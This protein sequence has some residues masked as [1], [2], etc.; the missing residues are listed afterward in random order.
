MKREGWFIVD[1]DLILGRRNMQ[2]K[3]LKRTKK[4][5]PL[6]SIAFETENNAVSE[7]NFMKN[8]GFWPLFT[9]DAR[10]EKIAF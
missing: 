5:V 9:P 3:L 2:E 10:I 8:W 6:G 7:L 4:G 1:N